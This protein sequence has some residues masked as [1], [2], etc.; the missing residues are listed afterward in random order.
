M[1]R[2][3]MLPL[4]CSLIACGQPENQ[5]AMNDT[6][7]NWALSQHEVPKDKASTCK[8]SEKSA[9]DADESENPE[10]EPVEPF[11]APGKGVALQPTSDALVTVI[12]RYDAGGVDSRWPDD[13]QPVNVRTTIA[14]FPESVWLASANAIPCVKSFAG[15]KQFMCD[16][17]Q[18]AAKV[19]PPNCDQRYG[20][21]KWN[22]KL[23]CAPVKLVQDGTAVKVTLE[24]FVYE[25]EKIVSPVVTQ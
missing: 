17:T 20:V 23:G 3:T 10:M 22:G 12:Y 4:V 6:A 24:R 16:F 9:P 14:Q 1:Y 2:F 18:E 7:K 15:P 8:P 21:N 19:T 25:E 5:Y 13:F 11:K